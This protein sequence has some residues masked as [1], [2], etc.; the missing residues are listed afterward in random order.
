[1][2]CLCISKSVTYITFVYIYISYIH[3]YIGT[4]IEPISDD[5]TMRMM[6]MNECM[7]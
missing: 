6:M 3:I 1:M 4:Y 7:Q 5:D 2:I